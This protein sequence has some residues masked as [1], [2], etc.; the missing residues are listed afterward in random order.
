M[1]IPYISLQGL[2]KVAILILLVITEAEDLNMVDGIL[3]EVGRML[4]K[5]IVN[6]I[7]LERMCY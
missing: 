4:V 5:E 7:V 6:T 2:L 3:V 1:E